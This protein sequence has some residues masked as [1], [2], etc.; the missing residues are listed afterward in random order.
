MKCPAHEGYDCRDN[1]EEYNHRQSECTTHEWKEH[2]LAKTARQ[3][4][5]ESAYV[6][7]YADSESE[8]QLIP[9]RQWQLQNL[10]LG[11]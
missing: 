10:V 5:K 11:T 8:Y 7:A 9:N 2:R 3:A 1:G 4:A 6:D